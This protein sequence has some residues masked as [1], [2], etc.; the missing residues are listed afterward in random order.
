MSVWRSIGVGLLV[1]TFSLPARAA[2]S[3]KLYANAE[4]NT[5]TLSIPTTIMAKVVEKALPGS[6]LILPSIEVT[7]RFGTAMEFLLDCG[8]M[9][10][11]RHPEK[12]AASLSVSASVHTL[13]GTVSYEAAESFVDD[14]VH[15]PQ[16]DVECV[17]PL[18]LT[19]QGGALVSAIGVDLEIG[20]LS[21]KSE[22]V[23][24]SFSA[25]P[26]CGCTRD[27]PCFAN[28]APRIVNV[29]P[30]SLDMN[31]AETAS[32]TVT[33]TDAEGNLALFPVTRDA[34]G[35]L[36]AVKV[37][38][39][40]SE[41]RTRGAATYLVSFPSEGEDLHAL[42]TLTAWDECGQRDLRSVPVRLFYPQKITLDPQSRW[43]GR[44]YM[45]HFTVSDP[46]FRGCDDPWE[47]VSLSVNE[48]SCGTY[49]LSQDVIS[50]LNTWDGSGAAT[51][52]FHPQ[53]DCCDRGFTLQAVDL[54]GLL[55]T[56][57]VE[58]PSRPLR[59]AGPLMGTA[60]VAL[61]PGAEVAVVEP[62][63]LDTVELEPSGETFRVNLGSP[64]RYAESYSFSVDSLGG[65]YVPSCQLDPALICHVLSEGDVL[66]DE[67]SVLVRDACGAE[68]EVPITVTILVE[69]RVPPDL[70]T[71]AQ[72]ALVECDGKGNSD[73]FTTWLAV[74]G[75]AVAHGACDLSVTWEYEIGDSQPA[76]GGTG[77]RAVKFLVSDRY[78]NQTETQ[79]S[80]AIQDTSPPELKLPED[81][82]VECLGPTDPGHTGWATAEDL[83]DP[84]EPSLGHSDAG[85]AGGCPHA[86][87]ITR[88]WTATDAC[89]NST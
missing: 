49:H 18:I 15:D 48:V 55:D 3:H 61:M 4:L 30:Q 46:N 35:T 27:E 69:N 57:R 5:T 16:P 22:Q 14:G 71:P 25:I 13:G 26:H 19:H 79:A 84:N 54:N 89:G 44:E 64:P 47:A 24:M 88:T 63:V 34:P 87:M 11:C 17:L 20:G 81:V 50:C 33:A 45:A 76:C 41:D 32:I 85:E 28:T 56:Y 58:V 2:C 9:P 38:D 10:C 6:S 65:Y 23:T 86:W 36:P 59:V 43:D 52:V 82:T 39:W 53:R 73:D 83:C 7:L 40:Y 78:G 51:V 80:F 72:N 1:L 31:K 60:A 62:V 70:V 8:C 21:L 66:V 42:V 74:H 75:G 29:F 37:H 67:F 68:L 12:Q 77:T